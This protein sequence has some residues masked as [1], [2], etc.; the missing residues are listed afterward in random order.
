MLRIA[1]ES[2]SVEVFE[3]DLVKGRLPSLDQLFLRD[4]YG[5]LP[6]RGLAGFYAAKKAALQLLSGR[7]TSYRD[8]LIS[9]SA[10]GA[11]RIRLMGT[12]PE[13]ISLDIVII[14]SA[15][16]AN[17]FALARFIS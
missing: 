3:R 17:A 9:L 7:E 14:E 8:L 1:T 11:P 6:F 13:L 10:D 16:H 4:E 5:S 12:I 15:R 2:V